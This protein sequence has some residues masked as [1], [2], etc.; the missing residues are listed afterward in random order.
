VIFGVM[1]RVLLWPLNQRAMR[2]SLRMQ[3]IQPLVKDIQ[4]RYKEDPQ[5]LQQETMRVYR[6]NKVNPFGGCL[7]VLLPW[8]IL[9]ALFFTFGNTIELRGASFLWLPDLAQP[10]PLYIIPILMGLSMFAAS[11]IGQVGLPPNPQTKVMLYV[12]PVMMTVFFSPLASGLNLYYTVQ[13]LASIP[14]QWLVV[15]ERL[16]SQPPPPPAP[17]AQVKTKGKR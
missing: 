12:M 5:R 2:S 17:V 7:P 10:D 1:V 15:K 4:E 3:A 14:Q 13:N 9:I 6:E 16:R 11:K 8:P